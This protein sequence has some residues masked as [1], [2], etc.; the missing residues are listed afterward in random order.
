M[1]NNFLKQSVIYQIFVRNYS[2]QGTFKKVMLDLDRI[3]DL[4]VDIIY[5]MPFQPIGKVGRKGS[6]GSPY[7][8]I[9]YKAIDKT[10][11]TKKDFI[12]LVNK[13]HE[14]K[15]KII[16]DIVFHH[17]AKD[18]LLKETHPEY[19]YHK[20]DGDFGNRVGEWDDVIDLDTERKDTQEYLM[21]VLKYWLD[22]GVDGFRFDVASLIPISFFKK[23]R[24]TFG[25][26]V[27]L[28]AESCEES[29]IKY[30]KT[31]NQ[32]VNE[33]EELYPTF[34]ISYDYDTYPYL[35]QFLTGEVNTI[36][37]YVDA[38]KNRY[39]T[40]P[41]GYIK[42][43]CLENH[44][45]KRIA[46]LVKNQFMLYNLLALS[47]FIEG[48]PFIYMGEEYGDDKDV[49]LFEK[50][51]LDWKKYNKGSQNIYKF[52][53]LLAKIKHLSFYSRIKS[54]CIDHDGLLIK[55]TL[56]DKFD[57]KLIGLFNLSDDFVTTEFDN[58]TYID[59]IRRLYV[60]VDDNTVYV[61]LPLILLKTEEQR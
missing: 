33:D 1:G 50:E 45:Q 9:D 5:L 22:L 16:I 43:N 51:P 17:T 21:S 40:L 29:F 15:M 10:H 2:K 53:K 3:K 48:T 4:G 49:P 28:L 25:R 46:S 6:V 13:I 30:L 55:V 35:K 8:I 39:K 42:I 44:D 11:G 18:A 38:I 52:I 23:V 61:G 19:Y 36:D 56:T 32:I 58:G 27:I 59:L 20:E 31:Q 12:Q 14:Y 57:N 47:F 34:D 54:F 41:Q 7:S 37:K 26:K 60:D 24:R